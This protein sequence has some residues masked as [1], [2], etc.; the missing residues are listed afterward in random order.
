MA[1]DINLS[2]SFQTGPAATP[3][4]AVNPADH[5]LIAFTNCEQV[6]GLALCARYLAD[7]A[8]FEMG[9]SP[10]TRLQKLATEL[11]ELSEREP[12]GLLATLRA[13]LALQHA[14]QLQQLGRQL[15]L[16][17]Q[18]GSQDWE[19]YLQRGVEDVSGDLAP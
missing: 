9:A 18:L 6:A 17:P 15:Q 16:A 10:A 12:V 3:A 1:D 13:E 2:Y 14:E 5:E 19:A 8:D 7:R 4:P 11:R